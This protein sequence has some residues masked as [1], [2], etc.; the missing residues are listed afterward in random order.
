LWLVIQVLKAFAAFFRA[1]VGG[2]RSVPASSEP[3]KKKKNAYSANPYKYI[4]KL[5]F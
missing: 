3:G 1:S 4:S 2:D 5:I